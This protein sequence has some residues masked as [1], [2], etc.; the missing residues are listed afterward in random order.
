MCRGWGSTYNPKYLDRNRPW[1][2]ADLIPPARPLLQGLFLYFSTLGLTEDK[3]DDHRCESIASGYKC[4]LKQPAHFWKID[5]FVFNGMK[6]KKLLSWKTSGV[7]RTFEKGCC[8]A[9]GW[10]SPPWAQDTGVTRRVGGPTGLSPPLLLYSQCF[11]RGLARSR[12]NRCG[13]NDPAVLT[14][15]QTERHHVPF[16]ARVQH[17]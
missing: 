2:S 16:A 17:T 7:S 5:Q 10:Q 13:R 1:K 8:P 3:V 9:R 14:E 15:P 12:S 11:E 6:G 4:S